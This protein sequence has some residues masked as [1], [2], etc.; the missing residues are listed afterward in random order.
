[1]HLLATR[2]TRR[3]MEQGKAATSRELEEL[4]KRIYTLVT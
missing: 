1:L 2:E 4:E 3:A